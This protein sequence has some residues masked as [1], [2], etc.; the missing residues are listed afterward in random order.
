MTWRGPTEYLRWVCENSQNSADL[1]VACLIALISDGASAQDLEPRAYSAAPIGTHFIVAG[2]GRSAGDV[3]ADTA[4]PVQDVHA[5]T[6]LATLGGGTTFSLFGRTALLLGAFPY[7]WSTVSGRV[8]ETSRT[9]T[10]SGLADPRIKL[11]VERV[12]KPASPDFVEPARRIA[13]F[14]NDGT[15]WAE[16]PLYFQF[17]F[18]LERVKTLAPQHPEWKNKEPFASLTKGDVK[19]ALAGGEKVLLE[20]IGCHS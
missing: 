9:V 11:F 2:W 13:T 10:P 17:L 1:I 20:V 16:Q 8:G 4:A 7:A 12:T 18:A 15:L 14:D 3:L 5:T 6:N 19:T